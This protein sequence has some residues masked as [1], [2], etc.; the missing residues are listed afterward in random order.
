MLPLSP[1]VRG[2]SD[3]FSRHILYAF[4]N[5]KP[6]TGEVV[7]S[8]LWADQDI[9]YPGD[10]WN[11]PGTNLY[12]NFKAIYLLKKQNRHLKLL[13]SI[14][15]WTYSPSFHPVVVNPALRA[16]F[17]RSAVQ[18]L[19]DYGLDGLDIDYEY[20][21]DDTQ[22]RGYVELLRELRAALDQHSRQ[23]NTNYR[24]L[25]TVSHYVSTIDNINESAL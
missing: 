20:P 4:A 22:A 13:L 21:Q 25:L 24:F 15:G 9:H 5:V 10:S 18:I 16:G 3:A 7:L 17:V 14:G 12:G 8:D 23:K 6:D 11:D 19:E 1:S 2:G